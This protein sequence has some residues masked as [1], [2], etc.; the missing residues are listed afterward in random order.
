MKEVEVGGTR[1]HGW[2]GGWAGGWSVDPI[3]T[4]LP[5]ARP[6]QSHSW[7]TVG[8]L[9][10]GRAVAAPPAEL[11]LRGRVKA[12]PAG[13]LA[14]VLPGPRPP[15]F[16]ALAE[17]ED[18]DDGEDDDAAPADPLLEL[19]PVFGSR[20]RLRAA[21]AG[22]GT[23]TIRGW[24]VVPPPRIFTRRSSVPPPP[25]APPPPAPPPAAAAPR[26][27][28]RA[29]A[30]PSWGGPALTNAARWGQVRLWPETPFAP[31][32][33]RPHQSQGTSS[34]TCLSI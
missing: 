6:H 28:L 4:R 11:L 2:V 25:P 13:L 33:M 27:E 8:P 1:G 15:S 16:D 20:S 5:N 18:E 29:P 7:P 3:P 32:H 12:P 9:A 23:Q 30:A 31:R 22:S 21:A 26:G 34:R 10:R 19:P 24:P 14:R 17:E